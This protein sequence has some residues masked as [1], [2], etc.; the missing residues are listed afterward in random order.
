MDAIGRKFAAA[1]AARAPLDDGSAAFWQAQRVLV[2]DSRGEMNS[3][4]A[5]DS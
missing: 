2:K 3:S 4:P 1:V 5:N